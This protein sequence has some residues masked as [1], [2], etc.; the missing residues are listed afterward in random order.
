MARP[1]K[2]ATYLRVMRELV[3][4]FF[5]ERLDAKCR[6]IDDPS[7]G[8]RL[9]LHYLAGSILTLKGS[10]HE[11]NAWPLQ[12]HAT[13]ARCSARRRC[14]IGVPT[15]GDVCRYSDPQERGETCRISSQ[16]PLH[17][18]AN[19]CARA[20]WR[21]LP[22]VRATKASRIIAMLWR[23][24]SAGSPTGC[25]FFRVS[26]RDRHFCR[27]SEHPESPTL[28]LRICDTGH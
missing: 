10:D 7:G 16:R 24:P 21:P 17:V 28:L 4:Y 26:R 15:A 27:T 11:N 1:S 13:G 3:R 14:N 6:R 22:K 19:R 12:P 25:G 18:N 5:R 8:F 2:T 20:F 23:K 9:H